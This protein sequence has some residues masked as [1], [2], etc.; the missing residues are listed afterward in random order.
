MGYCLSGPMQT[1]L[2]GKVPAA[3]SWH[4]AGHSS[5]TPVLYFTSP[6][7]PFPSQ[8]CLGRL[9]APALPVDDV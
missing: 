3:Q 7:N 4:G 6:V 5:S 1:L 2:Q 9:D 8:H